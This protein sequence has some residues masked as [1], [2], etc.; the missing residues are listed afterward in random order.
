ML[1]GT[2]IGTASDPL[3]SA[4]GKQKPVRIKWS[5]QVFSPL[6]N[7]TLIKARLLPYHKFIIPRNQKWTIRVDMSDDGKLAFEM[8]THEYGWVLTRAFLVSAID[9]DTLEVSTTV[10]GID[11]KLPPNRKVPNTGSPTPKPIIPCSEGCSYSFILTR[12]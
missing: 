11:F 2:W 6:K 7:K 5:I 3:Y 8:N 4:I 10:T 9:T 12:Q 1:V